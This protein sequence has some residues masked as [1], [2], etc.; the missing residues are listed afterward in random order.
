MG[1]V[2]NS[3]LRKILILSAVILIVSR[4][5]FFTKNIKEE[6]KEGLLVE[7]YTED[8]P[9]GVKFYYLIKSKKFK[10]A[11]K[12]FREKS[13]KRIKFWDNYILPY[14]KRKTLKQ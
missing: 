14:I 2:I 4:E 5:T 7:K 8:L 12:L 3:Y 11:Y 1:R 6:R 13:R 10:R 9:D